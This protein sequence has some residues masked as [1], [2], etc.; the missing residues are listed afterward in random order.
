M[1]S[2]AWRRVEWVSALVL[3]AFMV[4]AASPTRVLAQSRGAADPHRHGPSQVSLGSDPSGV[5]ILRFVDGKFECSRRR[6]IPANAASNE[7]LDSVP[8][9]LAMCSGVVRLDSR[10]HV[11]FAGSTASGHGGLAL[12]EIR[13]DRIFVTHQA[14]LPGRQCDALECSESWRRLFLL[15]RRDAAILT[16]PWEPGESFPTAWEVVADSGRIAALATHP[17]GAAPLGLRARPDWLWLGVPLG[18]L[19]THWEIRPDP[20]VGASHPWRV[21]FHQPPIG[22]PTLVKVMA[23]PS[24]LGPI[25]ITSGFGGFATLEGAGMREALAL[26]SVDAGSPVALQ[27]PSGTQL[28]SGARYTLTVAAPDGQRS[29][30]I[31][32]PLWRCGRGAK[33]SGVEFL[34]PSLTPRW[35][36]LGSTTFGASC[37]YPVES[38][39]DPQNARH[40][41]CYLPSSRGHANCPCEGRQP[42]CCAPIAFS[43]WRTR[44]PA[45]GRSAVSEAC[46]RWVSITSPSVTWRPRSSC[47]GRRLAPRTESLSA[48][49]SRSRSEP[50]TAVLARVRELER[51]QSE[52]G[53][54]SALSAKRRLLTCWRECESRC[55]GDERR[56]RPRPSTHPRDR[57]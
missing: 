9:P 50:P 10:R 7:V 33:G 6:M 14:E 11:L 57:A 21:E 55:V 41:W 15:D 28:T 36:T 8:S 56:A 2:D 48:R 26:G 35:A 38:E 44:N 46:F 30:A 49:S 25:E 18:S 5:R 24:V 52:R 13:D 40:S 1:S 31:V 17:R 47:A 12:V 43:S 19:G 42:H 27:L 51:P 20:S 32:T 3:P 4:A 34:E 22:S 16:A 37:R 23:A 53:V 45:S 54:D 39:S 29:S